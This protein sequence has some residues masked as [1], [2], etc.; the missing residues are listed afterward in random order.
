MA[1]IAQLLARVLIRKEEPTKVREDVIGFR[2]SYQTLSF[3]R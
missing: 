2:K 1:E 3:V